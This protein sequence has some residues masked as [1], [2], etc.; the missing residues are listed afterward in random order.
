[1]S[2]V[3][4]LYCRSPHADK[5]ANADRSRVT[6]VGARSHAPEASVNAR[7]VIAR[8]ARGGC[9]GGHA[10]TARAS[11]EG[12]PVL[13]GRRT[14]GDEGR[15]L[16]WKTEMG[17]DLGDDRGIFDGR[18]EAQAAAAAGTGEDVDGEDLREQA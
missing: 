18:D 17:E 5:P 2:D 7:R 15:Q 14:G 16:G 3:T 13:L 1:M 11:G 10:R 12:E 6:G 8:R 9:G 4:P